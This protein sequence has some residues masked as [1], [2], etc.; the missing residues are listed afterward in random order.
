MPVAAIVLGFLVS[1]MVPAFRL[2][3]ERIDQVN[4]V[5]REQ[6]T[7]I[8]VVRAFVREPQEARRFADANADLTA[9]S[10]RAGR[11]MSS[12]FPTV[13]FLINASSVAVLWLG[14][15]YV[16]KG[17]IEVGT[18]VAYL[19]YL[20]QILMSVVMATFMIS[21]VPRASVS[22]DRIQEVLDT[23]VS[24]IPPVRPVADQPTPG[25]LRLT[26]VGFNYPG[27]E[28]PVLS[29]ISFET[30]PGRT[31][32]IIGST[33]A[34][35]STLV[36]LIP[37]LFD[38]TARTV[39][40]GGVDVRPLD[41]HIL[42]ST[43]GLVPQRPYLFSG[44]VRSNLEFG[45]GDATDDEMWEALEVAQATDF[46]KAMGGLDAPIEQGGTNV[47]GGQ[48][49]RLSIARALVRKPDIYVFDDS[50]SALDLSTDARLRA[51]LAP[52]T[53]DA[54]VVIVAQRVSTISGA[55]DILVL[56]DGV[57]VG[58]GTHDELI[59]T[60]PTYEEIVQSQI[61]EREEAA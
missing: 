24:V 22:A 26:D 54:A 35:K 2:M 53:R 42:W 18:L 8:R 9:V 31:T 40:V 28:H 3:Q 5:L 33:G 34:A 21:M 55:D 27:A 6:I 52:Y 38:A 30:A 51:A 7:G 20:V 14:A 56:E 32:A 29:G 58:R 16:S 13:N 15:S 17:Q 44:T 1:R 36:N 41:P 12:M 49:Q 23:D 25:S 59:E 48:R 19:S 50:F 10:L 11:L 47:S 46:V 4:R 57:V 43:I 60:N 37:R 61:G 45:K 39:E